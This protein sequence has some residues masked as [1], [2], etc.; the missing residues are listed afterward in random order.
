MFPLIIVVAY[1]AFVFFVIFVC[2]KAGLKKIWLV[3]IAGLL[4]LA[5]FWDILLAKGI[6]WNYA[7]HNSPLRHIAGIVEQP[8]SVLWID[9]V[10]PG[11]D[12]YGR[13]W[14]VKNYLD[15]VHLKTLIL[16]GEDNKF[17]LYHATLKDFAESEKIRPAYEKM[18]KM[19]KKLKDEAK[20][21]AYKPGGNRALWQTIRQVHEPRLKKL[22]YK[23]TREREVEKIFARETVYPSLSRLPPVRYQVEFN[24]IR[25]PEW[26]EKYIWCDEITITDALA[27]SNIAYSKRCL[28]YTPMT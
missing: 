17:Y 8:E 27:N 7:R 4:L 20:S 18:N 23:Q 15:G 9:N 16:K 10:W 21:A 11:Y 19:I 28:E 14:M 12:A 6:M 26:Q 13:H 24:R 1:L 5:P 25:L 2:C 22:G 3:L